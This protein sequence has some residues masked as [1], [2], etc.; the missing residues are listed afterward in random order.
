VWSFSK[1]VYKVVSQSAFSKKWRIVAGL[2]I[3]MRTTNPEPEILPTKP[4]STVQRWNVKRCRSSPAVPQ[5]WSH[6]IFENAFV[7][8][9]QKPLP[10]GAG[11]T[12]R[13]QI[14]VTISGAQ[15]DERASGFRGPGTAKSATKPFKNE[16]R[17]LAIGTTRP[18]QLLEP[19]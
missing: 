8:F 1:R 12:N 14:S 3:V 4:W 11:F 2:Y 7:C 19:K 5:I 10:D 16:Q 9:F 15:P 13:S 18:E 6:T 17:C